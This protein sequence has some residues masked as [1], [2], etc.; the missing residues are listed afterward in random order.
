MLSEDEQI[1][2]NS[3]PFEQ[4]HEGGVKI[5]DLSN[6]QSFLDKKLTDYEEKMQKRVEDTYFSIYEETKSKHQ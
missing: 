2:Q 3:N 5:E 4:E 1:N 6:L